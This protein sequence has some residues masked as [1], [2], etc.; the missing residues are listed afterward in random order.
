MSIFSKIKES[1]EG[2]ELSLRWYK[3]KVNTLAGKEISARE[4]IRAGAEKNNIT[5]F[6]SFNMMNL[7]YY[8]PLYGEKYPYYDIY[9]LVLPFKRHNNGFTGINF[10]YLPIPLRIKMLER[11]QIF[12]EG[13]KIKVNWS[14]LSKYKEFKPTIKRYRTQRIRSKFLKIVS[15]DML[16][17]IL[18][19]VQQFY[20]GEWSKKTRV[21]EREVWR[22]S[23]RIIKNA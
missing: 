14:V 1:S 18:L 6:P 23:R 17:A 19:P 10:H 4:H 7:F 20:S 12:E 21:K 3:S 9:P 11:I 8:N 5:T 2:R 15:E 13:D 22:D 16:I